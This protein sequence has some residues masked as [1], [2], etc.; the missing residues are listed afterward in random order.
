MP[1]AVSRWNEN[2]RQKS[3]I[4][5]VAVVGPDKKAGLNMGREDLKAG[6]MSILARHFPDK[7]VRGAPAYVE[8]F[9]TRSLKELDE[10]KARMMCE[11][12][13]DLLVL[14]GGDGNTHLTLGQ[15]KEF[16]AHLTQD[17]DRAPKVV[18]FKG[19][20]KNIVPGALNLLGDDPLQAFDVVCQKILLGIPLDIVCCPILKINE[21]HGFIYGSGAVTNA[22]DEYYRHEAGRGRG[23]KTGLCELWR[24]TFGK[25]NPWKRPSVFRSFDA[26]AY[27]RDAQG[28]EQLVPKSRFNA[29]IASSLREINPWLKVTH[30]TGE[31]LGCFH[32]LGLNNGFWRS[33]MNLPAMI[34][35]A[36][37]L[38]AV[39]DMVT[40][41]LVIRYAQAMRHTVDGERYTTEQ[42]GGSYEPHTVEIQTGPFIQF[43]V[44]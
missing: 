44:S 18:V 32:G 13:P 19:G 12:P 16:L 40:D 5:K 26:K 36:P 34:V 3:K 15:N 6:V 27:W 22:L 29:F 39:Q 43:V 21:L 42:L 41:R 4:K 35:G 23:L 38:G 10:A 2:R 31:R 14:I 7:P 37:M 8:M 1:G 24:Q 9:M 33:A 30:R 28:Q 17:P 25:L 11:D 20:S